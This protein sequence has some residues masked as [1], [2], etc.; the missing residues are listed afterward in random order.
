MS[1]NE[2]NSTPENP[3]AGGSS[4]D[5][6]NTDFGAAEAANNPSSTDFSFTESTPKH[7]AEAQSGQDDQPGQFGQAP[8][9]SPSASGG[10]DGAQYGGQQQWQGGQPGYQQN[11]Y[12]Q[13]GYQQQGYQ[14]GQPQGYQNGQHHWQGGQPGYQQQSYPQSGYQQQGYQGGHPQGHHNL[15]AQQQWQGAPANFAPQH[16]GYGVPM[17]QEPKSKVAAALLAFFLGVFGAH[18]FYLGKTGRGVAQLGLFFFGLISSFFLIGIFILIG[19]EI[20]VLV[21]FIMILVGS[22]S[23]ARDAKGVPLK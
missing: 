20:W 2:N 9:V 19:L 23:M 17:H 8:S 3:Y 14:G 11:G 4:A 1:D 21:E 7:S 13:N 6:S 5:S 10:Q 12:Q 16:Q 22:G 15:P 18:N